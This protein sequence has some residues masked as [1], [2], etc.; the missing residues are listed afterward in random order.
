MYAA[1]LNIFS[2]K[3]GYGA[4]N[5]LQLTRFPGADVEV[6]RLDESQKEVVSLVA[7]HAL[8]RRLVHIGQSLSPVHTLAP[9]Q[10]IDAL[11]VAVAAGI[12]GLES[13]DLPFA[14]Q[15]RIALPIRHSDPI[16]GWGAGACRAQFLSTAA[17]E[18]EKIQALVCNMALDGRPVPD[19]LRRVVERLGNRQLG[20]RQDLEEGDLSALKP[21]CR[22]A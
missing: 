4:R 12:M 13:Q 17:R 20:N 11:L 19:A 18:E 22:R 5:V 9:L 15:S 14:V 2:A 6:P 7:Q 8:A 16:P 10:K 3:A 1:V 21:G